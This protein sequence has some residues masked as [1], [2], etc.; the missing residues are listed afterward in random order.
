MDPQVADMIAGSLGDALR[1]LLGDDVAAIWLYGAS[2]FG[3]PSIDLDVHVLLRRRLTSKEWNAVR[4]LHHQL[5]RETPLG[6]DELDFWY[7][8]LASARET[9]PPSHMAP[10][11]KGLW[12]KHWALHRA[13]WLAG[14]CR[15]VHGLDPS[16]VV[17]KPTW[18]E[19]ES[20]LLTE[21]K[22]VEADAYWVLQLCRVWASLATRNVVRSKI[23]SGRWAMERLS[24]TYYDMIH[25]AI[26]YY[27]G[28]EGPDDPALI[29]MGFPEFVEV[30][31]R[32][33]LEVAGR[34]G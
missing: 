29:R 3:H 15:I 21:L 33:I 30:V 27:E 1:D 25:A 12:D 28:S 4:E 31:R 5:V 19:L 7:I 34:L 24:E 18:I 26:R 16:G 17:Q 14:Q 23:D 2:T 6:L 22:N 10:W 8:L 9:A 13:H 32:K 11:C 20:I